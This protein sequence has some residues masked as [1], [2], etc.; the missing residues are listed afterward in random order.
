MVS[1]PRLWPGETVACIA[2]G[3][4]LSLD[5]VAFVRGKVRVIA[6]ND[7]VR[8]APWADVLYSSDR[9]WWPGFARH[10]G[11]FNGLKYGVGEHQGQR[12][13]FRRCPDVTVL[14]N[15]GEH[16]VETDPSGLR[17]G[18]NSGAAAINLAV[19]FGAARVLLLGYTMSV[20]DN[21]AHF[22]DDGPARHTLYRSWVR[23]FDAMR[24]PLKALGVEVINCTHPTALTSFPCASARDVLT[25]AEV[26]A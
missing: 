5:D 15:T 16:G 26:A 14:T 8:V 4:S 6:V 9:A 20:I 22:F 17:T 11:A 23:C 21:R 19:H 13:P 3:P 18:S 25:S 7:A 12:E 1:A 2:S 24:A 10:G